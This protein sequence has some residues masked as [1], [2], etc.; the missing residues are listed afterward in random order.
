M[1]I[2][3]KLIHF[4]T[5]EKFKENLKLNEDGT[6]AD[7]SNILGTSI[8]FIKDAKLIWT[9]GQYYGYDSVSDDLKERL[10]SIE[11]TIEENELITAR[12]LV[13]LD[14]NK[15]NIA[16]T[17]EGYG[18]TDAYTKEEIDTKVEEADALYLKKEDLPDAI[19]NPESLTIQANGTTLDT[20]DGSSAKTINI[21][22]TDL[23]LSSALKYCGITTTN[24][25]DDSTAETIVIDGSDHIATAGCV[26][27][28]GDKEFVYNGSKWEE[29]GYPVDLSSYATTSWVEE[30]YKPKQTE[31]SDPTAEGNTTSFIDSISQD[32][33]GVITV[34]KKNVDFSEYLKIE[35]ADGSVVTLSDDYVPAVYPE[36]TGD[37]EFTSLI[38]GET[39]DSAIKKLDQNLANVVG[40]ILDNE[41]VMAQALTDLNDNKTTLAEVDAIYLK[42]ENLPTSLK[43]PYKLTIK[44]NDTTL[45]DYDGSSSKSVNLSFN[46]EEIT[47]SNNYKTVE[48]GGNI[49]FT[50][51]STGSTLDNSLNNLESNISSLASKVADNELVIATSLVDLNDRLVVEEKKSR[52]S[53]I[54]SDPELD[55]DA[56]GNNVNCYGYVG[57]LENLNFSEGTV[58]IDTVSVYVREGSASPNL[59]KEVWCRILRL[60]NNSWKV[61]SQSE[62]S[63]SIEGIAPETLFT[64]KMVN[65]GT[66]SVIKTSERIAIVYVDSP[67]AAP[68]SGIQLGFKSLSKPGGLQN[69]LTES[70][71]G[72]S[73]WCPAFVFE[74]IPLSSGSDEFVH[75]T[76][77][78]EISGNKTFNSQAR[79][80][81][82]IS[83]SGKSTIISDI[84]SGEL[85]V[86][87]NNSSKGF[88]LRTKNTSDDILPLELLS[89]NTY[90]S[91]QYNFP[92][93]GGNVALG[94]KTGNN[95]YKSQI[96]SG[97]INFGGNLILKAIEVSY[98]ELKLMCSEKRLIPGQTYRIIDYLTETADTETVSEKKPFDLIVTAIDVDKLGEDAN[99]CAPI[100]NRSYYGANQIGL[101]PLKSESAN[102]LDW[103]ELEEVSE[104]VA[105]SIID[106]ESKNNVSFGNYKVVEDGYTVTITGNSIRVVIAQRGSSK[107][108]SCCGVEVI[109]S[110]TNQVVSSN[111]RVKTVPMSEGSIIYFFTGLEADRSYQVRMKFI[112]I[113]EPGSINLTVEISDYSKP[114]YVGIDF[115]KWELKYDINNDTTKYSWADTENG[116]GVIYYLKDEWGNEC[117]YDFKNIKFKRTQEWRTSYPG[118]SSNNEYNFS[119]TEKYFYTFDYNGAD[120]SLNQGNYKCENNRIGKCMSGEKILLNNTLFFGNGNSNNKLG[121]NNKNNVFGYDTYNNII[122]VNCQNNVFCQKF[123]YN[124]VGNGFKNNYCSGTYF[125][126]NEVEHLFDGNTFNG[127]VTRCK[128]SGEFKN[129]TVSGLVYDSIFGSNIQKCS[130]NDI[131][132]HSELGNVISNTTNFPGLYKVKIVS[133]TLPNSE[134]TDLSTLTDAISGKSLNEALVNK[135]S[136]GY[137]SEEPICLYKRAKEDNSYE[138]CVVKQLSEAA[139]SNI[140]DLSLTDDYTPSTYPEN[141]GDAEF[142]ELLPGESLSSVIQK[143]DQNLVTL[144]EETIKNEKVTAQGLAELNEKLSNS[145]KILSDD[146]QPSGFTLGGN[147]VYKKL[148]SLEYTADEIGT[149]KIWRLPCSTDTTGVNLTE[150]SLVLT[151]LVEGFDGTISFD[152]R[153][154]YFS[155]KNNN[156][157]IYYYDHNSGEVVIRFTSNVSTKLLGTI[158]FSTSSVISGGDAAEIVD[159]NILDGGTS[160]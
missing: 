22:P 141:T 139:I 91:Y 64:F 41:E 3:K 33:D 138:Y 68:N 17:L 159:E 2:N 48:Y 95:V 14:K 124:Q 9:H 112:K 128:F 104:V 51:I 4:N 148:I 44:K 43:N 93:T 155:N 23:G 70:S 157:T 15:A 109:D 67:E 83:I 94:A 73:S 39:L 63:K 121:E 26:V 30:N 101:F 56:S 89:T 129:N 24:I 150:M 111:Y 16:D 27:F 62:K 126:Y 149:E 137:F 49:P 117:Y 65:R 151:Q 108:I 110:N 147:K 58:F 21:T 35:D 74:Y 37:G 130:F 60:E 55:F 13:E 85:K 99:A 136:N 50:S 20:Y 144:V 81:N 88:I 106:H 69:I 156:Q 102:P 66:E 114:Y 86:F 131:I 146:P 10:D 158:C 120:D 18:I 152:F 78:E 47:V 79:F 36:D 160:I 75:R 113:E 57:T 98:E 19:K 122:G 118:L 82:N 71:T 145:D 40:E 7:D 107:A 53:P 92:K 32:V 123:T 97:L 119:E 38:S 52:I 28:F 45:A 142:T 5:L 140:D 133:N 59:D 127:Y 42:K 154:N 135:L 87:H 100:E 8:V 90:S 115:S 143:L 11:A 34:T 77:D 61:I 103:S 76:G 116:K 72:H 6:V 1:A 132:G 134:T 84:D 96:E 29:L 80:N 125:R 153:D 46:T 12:A 105:N 54:I 31:V 25:I